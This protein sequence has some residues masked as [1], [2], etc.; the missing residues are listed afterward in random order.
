MY[1]KADSQTS[2]IPIIALTAHAIDSDREEA[3]KCGCDD[4][5]TKP[6]DMSRLL[7]KITAFLG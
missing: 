6:I 7:T 5:D 2:D 1:L 3:L 4:F